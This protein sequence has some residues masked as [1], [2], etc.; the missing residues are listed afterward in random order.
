MLRRSRHLNWR[1]VAGE[2]AIVAIG[3]L[4]A[5]SLDSWWS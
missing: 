2:I 4:I 5:F 1:Y 3:I